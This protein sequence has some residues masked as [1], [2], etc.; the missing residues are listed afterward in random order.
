MKKSVAPTADK[1]KMTNASA[2]PKR[3]HHSPA[4]KET[5]SCPVRM[6]VAPA[7]AK[8]K[9]SNAS[10]PSMR[11]HGGEM[12]SVPVWMLNDSKFKRSFPSPKNTYIVHYVMCSDLEFSQHF[13]AIYG[14]DTCALQLNEEQLAMCQAKWQEHGRRM[15]PSYRTTYSTDPFSS[16][17]L[18][19][20]IKRKRKRASD[21]LNKPRKPKSLYEQHPHL[22]QDWTVSGLDRTDLHPRADSQGQHITP[23]PCVPTFVS[24]FFPTALAKVV[25]QLIVNRNPWSWTANSCHLDS[26][27]MVELSVYDTLARRS[28]FGD[29]LVMTSKRLQR[30]FKVLLGVGADGQNTLRDSYWAMEIEEWGGPV[31]RSTFGRNDDYDIHRERLYASTAE[32]KLDRMNRLT[33]TRSVSCSSPEHEDALVTA[34]M[35]SLQCPNAW[36][37]MP[38]NSER[39]VHMTEDNK[40]EWK[41]PK[42]KEHLLTGPADQLASVAARSDSQ[43]VPCK[44]KKGF[45]VTRKLT[46][47]VRMPVSLAFQ[48]HGSDMPIPPSF[49]FGGLAY[50][51]LGVVFGNKK[52]FICNVKLKGSWYRYDDLGVKA[53]GAAREA[54]RS[55]IK[56]VRME[57]SAYLN[58]G[59]PGYHPATARYVRT[60]TETLIPVPL[61]SPGTVPCEQQFDEFSMLWEDDEEDAA[62]SGPGATHVSGNKPV[63]L[64]TPRTPLVPIQRKRPRSAR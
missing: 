21:P 36:Y 40:P 52:H 60:R 38:A 30:L 18:T 12:L 50:Q 16:L 35:R 23:P 25:D 58:P 45:A 11:D 49:T 46:E 4:S 48:V 17:D 31:A 41:M 39:T 13:V 47:G 55:N 37:S 32:G 63:A 3:D 6:F 14:T 33:V 15:I 51:L 27:L 20:K 26:W 22:V 5:H 10:A 19:G 64:V 61:L 24:S 9:M 42:V 29:L 53:V 43:H 62:S 7:P 54:P 44:C 8:G 56:L 2:P 34:H 59:I 1:G 28:S 57:S